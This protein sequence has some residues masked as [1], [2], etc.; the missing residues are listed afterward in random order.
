MITLAEAC[1]L[2][3][4]QGLTEFLPVSS[5][6]HLAVAQQF[7][8][9]LPPDQKVAIDVALHLGTLAAV[10]LYFRADLWAMARAAAGRSEEWAGRWIWLIVLA[11]VPVGVTGLALK[12]QIHETYDSL[13][14]IAFCFLLNGSLLYLA[15][16]VRGA[17][18]RENHLGPLDALVVGGFQVLA[19]LPGVSRSGTTI[20]GGLFRRIR[21]DVAAKFSFLMSVP[22]IAGAQVVEAPAVVALGPAAHVPVIAGILVSAAT[23]IAAIWALMRVVRTGR[24]HWFAYYTWALGLVVLLLA[25]TRS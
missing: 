7:M 23:G 12:A 10:L 9:P 4:V 18:R 21:P 17:L 2:G 16:A 5:D 19:L 3:V 11:T 25:V 15:T 1:I 22:A 13:F 8:T 14:L 20:A 24:L 6:G